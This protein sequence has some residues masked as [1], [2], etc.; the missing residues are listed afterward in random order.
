MTE[1]TY[2]IYHRLKINNRL[3]PFWW[4]GPTV[5]AASL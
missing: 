2:I 4:Y 5:K 1:T 3:E